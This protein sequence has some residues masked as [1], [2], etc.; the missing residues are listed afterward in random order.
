VRETGL[1]TRGNSPLAKDTFSP[2]RLAARSGRSASLSGLYA[3][4]T[5]RKC[6]VGLALGQQLLLDLRLRWLRVSCGAA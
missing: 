2:M 5:C 1:D 3:R 6:Q 4:N